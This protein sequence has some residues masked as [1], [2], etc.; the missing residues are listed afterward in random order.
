MCTI[1]RTVKRGRFP[2]TTG[3]FALVEGW[4]RETALNPDSDLASETLLQNGEPAKVGRQQ[5]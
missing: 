1:I 4:E 3:T 2:Q 5:Q